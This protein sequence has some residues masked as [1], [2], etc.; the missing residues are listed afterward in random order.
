MLNFIKNVGNIR[1][2]ESR[3]QTNIAITTD[4]FIIEPFDDNFATVRAKKISAERWIQNQLSYFLHLRNL[5][6]ALHERHAKELLYQL[7]V[8]TKVKDISKSHKEA[9]SL[10]KLPTYMNDVNDNINNNNISNK[11]N[12]YYH[13]SFNRH[14]YK[15]NYNPNYPA[16]L[17]KNHEST[18]KNPTSKNEQLVSG[19]SG[20]TSA[21][22][23]DS[24]TSNNFSHET[25]SDNISPSMTTEKNSLASQDFPKVPWLR[26]V[27]SEPNH[28]T[29]ENECSALSPLLISSNLQTANNSSVAVDEYAPIDNYN[30]DSI[31]FSLNISEIEIDENTSIN[32]VKIDDT[33]TIDKHSLIE[34]L[35]DSASP[36]DHGEPNIILECSKAISNDEHLSNVQ[37][38]N[39]D[40]NFEESSSE[41]RNDE[42]KKKLKEE[43][44]FSCPNVEET[45]LNINNNNNNDNNESTSSNDDNISE[46]EDNSNRNDGNISDF[47]TL[48]NTV[49]FNNSNKYNGNKTTNIPIANKTN[50][51]TNN[52]INTA[53]QSTS[54]ILPNDSNI[55][56][57][58]QQSNLNLLNGPL[59]NDCPLQLNPIINMIIQSLPNASASTNTTSNN[60]NTSTA[61]ANPI[62]F[63]MLN[64]NSLMSDNPMR[65]NPL[66]NIVVQSLQ[67]FLNSPS[68]NGNQQ[69]NFV[70]LLN[71]CSL[72]MNQSSFNATNNNTTTGKKVK[73]E[74]RFVRKFNDQIVQRNRDMQQYASLLNKPEK[75][76]AAPLLMKELDMPAHEFTTGD[77][78]FDGH[79]DLDKMNDIIQIYIENHFK[80]SYEW[81]YEIRMDSDMEFYT[82]KFYYL[83]VTFYR[84]EEYN[85]DSW[86]KSKHRIVLNGGGEKKNQRNL[87]N[88]FPSCYS[89]EVYWN[90]QEI[91]NH[92]S[93]KIY[94]IFDIEDMNKNKNDLNSVNLYYTP[95]GYSAICSPTTVAFRESWLNEIIAKKAEVIYN[96]MIGSIVQVTP[97]YGERTDITDYSQYPSSFPCLRHSLPARLLNI[98]E[99]HE[100]PLPNLLNFNADQQFQSFRVPQV[101][102][103]RSYQQMKAQQQDRLTNETNLKAIELANRILLNQALF[104]LAGINTSINPL[105][106]LMNN[107]NG[108]NVENQST[109]NGE[110]NKKNVNQSSKHIQISKQERS[111]GIEISKYSKKNENHYQSKKQS[112]YKT[113]NRKFRKRR[114]NHDSHRQSQQS[115]SQQFSRGRWRNEKKN[116]IN[117][118]GRRNNNNN[119]NQYYNTNE[120]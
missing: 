63:N 96:F 109:T 83:T 61:N 3:G 86:K 95:E 71:L 56:N 28:I 104:N 118:F 30:L 73:N 52:N 75:M 48:L 84:S 45:N 97:K 47:R 19:D 119:N 35:D 17:L 20:N 94:F 24:S 79:I 82:S 67:N 12:N 32:D 120:N 51:T 117:H 87:A 88:L 23:T 46:G 49:N 1:Q 14:G 76:Y 110:V 5:L 55:S 60:T 59:I 16:N 10:T 11:R 9:L 29:S 15:Y 39:E 99:T 93:A 111:G 44:K 4:R 77:F 80:F 74:R 107:N 58:L 40:E 34:F 33:I 81:T 69:N 38:L 78:Y 112:N 102:D 31:N 105:P 115:S 89:N 114:V 91:K 42:P 72:L 26:N 25:N 21:K 100:P 92:L 43:E 108:K 37:E 68:N 90:L 98:V 53:P 70:Q 22:P 65:M 85:I 8:W 62:N 106:N 57:N 50:I 113:P 2:S 13:K 18:S 41:K 27:I 103:F 116:D 7:C 66:F 36:N 101:N 64:C 6:D 54:N